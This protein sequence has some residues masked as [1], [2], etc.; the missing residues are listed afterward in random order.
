MRV[1][2]LGLLG[3]A[4]AACSNKP[5]EP[6]PPNTAEASAAAAADS[7]A[8]DVLTREDAARAL[9]R[10]VEKL[11]NQGGAAGQDICQFGY[12]GERLADMGNVSVTVQPV[13]LA[14]VV[15][16]ARAQGYVLEPVAGVGE[17]A[18]YSPDVGLY[19][20]KGQRT[21]HYLLGAQG[22]DDPKDKLIALARETV[23]RL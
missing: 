9:G 8:C 17:A 3:A 22:L 5:E 10:P 4:I 2:V 20:G 19:V 11:D 14:S 23:G 18:W 15:E 21:A 16:G 6:A 1:I 13:D 7:R 12:Q